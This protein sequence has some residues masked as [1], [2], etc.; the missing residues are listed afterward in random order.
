MFKLK[1]TKIRKW[2]QEY[3][4]KTFA[5]NDCNYINSTIA[6]VDYCSSWKVK[7]ALKQIIK[8][9]RYSYTFV[10]DQTIAAIKNWNQKHYQIQLHDDDIILVHGT[11]QFVNVVINS[12]T[13]INDKIMTAIP[14]YKPLVDC[15]TNNQRQLI[16][17]HLEFNR[18][19]NNFNF[20]LEQFIE[21]IKTHQPKLYILCHPHNP[22]Q[23]V[24]EQ[25]LMIKIAAICHQYNVILLVDEVHRDLVFNK[26]KF[27]SSLQLPLKYLNNI[28][29]CSSANKLFNLGGLKTSYAVIFNEQLKKQ[30]LAF[31]TQLNIS[32]P[33]IFAQNAIIAAYTNGTKFMN[34]KIKY[35]QKQIQYFL[36][37]LAKNQINFEYIKPQS[38]FMLW[39]KIA[40]INHHINYLKKNGIFL[41]YS[42][43]FYHFKND[44]IRINV[45]TKKQYLR[46]IAKAIGDIMHDEL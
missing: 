24:W 28:I 12:C 19:N 43:D 15:I 14:I 1:K 23:V 30:I 37:L 21:L 9:N 45:A 26:I 4:K 42:Q 32:S 20:D 27:Y 17:H 2:S 13:N 16:T 40:N 7:R 5:Y 29:F 3:I 34:K 18:K 22:G 6:D 46:T 10:S 35:F 36:F 41:S 38:S 11:V 31:N 44:W 25:N 8:L 39:I 33:N